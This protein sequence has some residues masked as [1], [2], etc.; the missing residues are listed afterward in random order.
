MYSN[1]CFWSNF[2]TLCRC[3]W[4]CFSGLSSGPATR[5][6]YWMPG[7]SENH[8]LSRGPPGQTGADPS[9]QALWLSRL[10]ENTH[11]QFRIGKLT[12]SNTERVFPNTCQNICVLASTPCPPFWSGDDT[13]RQISRNI[14]MLLRL[15]GSPSE[16]FCSSV[17]WIA[18][19]PVY[20]FGIL[21]F[22]SCEVHFSHL[23]VCRKFWWRRSFVR[24]FRECSCSSI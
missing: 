16:V 24:I 11:R 13:A 20:Y 19:T 15:V 21:P 14:G 4:L 18:G 23:A 7:T 9:P 3:K 22:L 12:L 6:S 1:F 17:S 5:T 2:N 8:V 10:C